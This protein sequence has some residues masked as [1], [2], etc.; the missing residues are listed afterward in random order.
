MFKFKYKVRLIDKIIY[1]KKRCLQVTV[2]KRKKHTN[3]E[4]QD[5]LPDDLFKRWVAL[6]KRVIV[7]CTCTRDYID[8]DLS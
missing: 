2:L 4:S 5:E 1:L 3:E 8:S 7:G 6:K